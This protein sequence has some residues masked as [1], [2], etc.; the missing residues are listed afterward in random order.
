MEERIFLGGGCFWGVQHY[1]NQIEGVI[2]TSVGFMGGITKNPTYH[3]VC[4]KNTGHIEVVEVVYDANRVTEET[5]LKMFFEIHDPTTFN[6]QGPDVGVQY[7]SVIFYTTEKQKIVALNLI[8]IL[9]QKFKVVTQVLEAVEYFQAE[10]YHQDYYL[11]NG[12]EPYC[13]FYVKKF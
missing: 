4:T 1:L 13:H 3:E 12:K 8:D 6:R 2:S 5:I 10:S 11:K 9:N 7:R